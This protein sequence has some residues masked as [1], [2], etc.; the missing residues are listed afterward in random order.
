MVQTKLLTLTL[1]PMCGQQRAKER[2]INDSQQPCRFWF[3]KEMHQNVMLPGNCFSVC[4]Y[5]R[6]VTCLQNW[7]TQR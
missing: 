2:Q 4:V 3:V 1:S 7:L 6:K 5:L